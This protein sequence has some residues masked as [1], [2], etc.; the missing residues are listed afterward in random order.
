MAEYCIVTRFKM[1]DGQCRRDEIRVSNYEEATQI[2]KEQIE[3]IGRENVILLKK[4][5]GI[6]ITQK[7]G[8]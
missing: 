6:I 5:D 3:L 7:E 8:R 2:E 1:P 4:R